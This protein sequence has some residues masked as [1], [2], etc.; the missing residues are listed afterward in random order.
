MYEG[1][2]GERNPEITDDKYCHKKGVS[3]SS[4][5]DESRDS[6]NFDSRSQAVDLHK[7]VNLKNMFVKKDETDS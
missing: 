5:H 3:Q 1:D 6:T 7:I 2:S 4:S